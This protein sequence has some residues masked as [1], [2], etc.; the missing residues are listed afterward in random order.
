M[1]HIKT[2]TL[3]DNLKFDFTNSESAIDYLIYIT[4]EVNYRLIVQNIILL[5]HKDAVAEFY[6][7]TTPIN[8]I[9]VYF[10]CLINTV[11]FHNI[12]INNNL[13]FSFHDYLL[14]NSIS[15]LNRKNKLNHLVNNF[16]KILMYISNQ[17]DVREF[18]KLDDSE[19]KNLVKNFYQKHKSVDFQHRDNSFTYDYPI[20]LPLVSHNLMLYCIGYRFQL[21]YSKLLNDYSSFLNTSDQK[22]Q[23]AFENTTDNVTF[24]SQENPFP[25]F[26]S[27]HKA[28]LFFE[29]LCDEI[30]KKEKTQ[31]ADYSFVFRRLQK[32]SLIYQ[33]ISEKAFR[34]FLSNKYQVNIDKLKTLDYSSTGPKETIY[35]MLRT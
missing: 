26:F 35:N 19:A 31:L 23:H 25:R 29:R 3:Y 10:F 34:E 18:N 8:P 32:D 22:K 28:F 13:A 14:D 12:F 17:I 24:H 33:D 4:N 7:N 21:F 16:D 27:N 15:E 30:C 6:K 9:R 5:G 1:E 11:P 2:I 20:T